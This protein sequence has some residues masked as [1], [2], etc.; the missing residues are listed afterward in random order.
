MFKIFAIITLFSGALHF[1]GNGLAQNKLTVIENITYLDSDDSV[2]SERIKKISKQCNCFIKKNYPGIKTLSVLLDIE[3]C[4]DTTYYQLGYD[5]IYGNSVYNDIYKP[6]TYDFQNLGIR[7][8]A[9]SKTVKLENVLKLLDHGLRNVEA[10]K[11]MRTKAMG[12]D[13]YDRPKNITLKA[14]TI[15]GILKRYSPLIKKATLN[16]CY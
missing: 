16:P 9:C 11:K 13:Y 8:K 7:I 15:N 12:L 3:D 5:N 10:L 2:K 4:S 14:A 6:K 1:H